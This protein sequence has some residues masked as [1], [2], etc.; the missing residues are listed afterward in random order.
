[1]VSFFHDVTTHRTPDPDNEGSRRLR[2]FGSYLFGSY[3]FRPTRNDASDFGL[4]YD[5]TRRQQACRIH[6][7]LLWWLLHYV[8][9]VA[10]EGPQ[11][12]RG[13]NTRCCS[14][15]LASRRDAGGGVPLS[16][17]YSDVTY[18]VY[19]AHRTPYRDHRCNFMAPPTRNIKLILSG[20]LSQRSF[21]RL[22]AKLLTA[23]AASSR[24]R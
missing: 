14:K 19:S 9:A 6:C 2:N 13:V 12:Y 16:Q 3:L 7:K 21:H 5:E 10:P 24:S 15:M 18:V 11:R 17:H 4:V 22:A 8:V 20:V 1:M 23:S